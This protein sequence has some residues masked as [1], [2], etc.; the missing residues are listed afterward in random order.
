MHV[1]DLILLLL[2]LLFQVLLLLLIL[3][4]TTVEVFALFVGHII[5]VFDFS[6]M[7]TRLFMSILHF[8]PHD[9]QLFQKI[10]IVVLYWLDD[11][12]SVLQNELGNVQFVFFDVLNLEIRCFG[13]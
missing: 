6:E 12:P 7:G 4:N 9:V 1:F 10:G 5:N 11:F 3:E 2:D 13:R 8:L